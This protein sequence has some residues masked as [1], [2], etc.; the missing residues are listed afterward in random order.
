MNKLLKWSLRIVVVL[1]ILLLLA[2]GGF[3]LRDRILYADFYKVAEKEMK[4]PGLWDGYVSQGFDYFEERDVYLTCGYQKSGKASR[5]Y[6]LDGEERIRVDMKEADGSDYIGHTGGIDTYGKYIYITA[7]TGCDLFL[8]DDVFDGDGVATKV[9][10]VPTCNDPAYC[11]IKGDYLYVGSFYDPGKYETPMEH[12]MVTPTGEQNTAILA[13][14]ELDSISGK[15]LSGIPSFVFST[16][17]QIQ[18]M[19]FVSDDIIVL[20]SSYGLSTGKLRFYDLKQVQ[21]TDQTLMVHD[22]TVPVVFLDSDSLIE[23]VELPPMTEEI[24]Y[25]DGRIY[26]MN[27]SACAKYWFGKL[28]SGNRVRSIPL[29]ESVQ[30]KLK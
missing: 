2:V 30:A 12:R 28:T 10:N 20:S 6:I 18:G 11:T 5:I 1:V 3:I 16:T 15:P 29:P 9:C 7:T 23:T 13:V 19:T 21:V 4:I 24:V 14:Y 27:E 22:V 25:R 26:I 17:S 8:I